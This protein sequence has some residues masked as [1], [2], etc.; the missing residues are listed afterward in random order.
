VQTCSSSSSRS[1]KR[2]TMTTYVYDIIEQVIGGQIDFYAGTTIVLKAI[3]DS[4]FSDEF[5]TIPPVNYNGFSDDE[6]IR[7]TQ[8]ISCFNGNACDN[9]VPDRRAP[10][11]GPRGILG[12]GRRS[13][14]TV[15]GPSRIGGG[16]SIIRDDDTYLSTSRF[17][18]ETAVSIAASVPNVIIATMIRQISCGGKQCGRRQGAR[19]M[20]VYNILFANLAIANCLSTV[21]L[22]F[23]NNLIYLFS[24]QLGRTFKARPC[25]FF[26][27]VA[28][29]VFTS[30][31]FGFVTTLTMLGF[32]TVQYSAICRPL[33]HRS[34]LNRCKIVIFLVVIW[35]ASLLIGLVPIGYLWASV[36]GRPCGLHRLRL[37]GIVV[38]RGAN[39][40]VAF[41]SV[42][43]F[44]IFVQCALIFRRMLIVRREMTPFRYARDMRTERRAIITIVILLLT[45]N[46]F[47]VPYTVM[48]LL[49]LNWPSTA[50]TE[51][52]ALVYYM[53]LLPHFKC[54]VDPIVYG[55]RMREMKM[56][57]TRLRKLIGGRPRRG[58]AAA[59]ASNGRC[60]T[61]R[62]SRYEVAVI[63]EAAMVETIAVG[64]LE[65]PLTS[66]D[67]TAAVEHGD[68]L[69]IQ[70]SNHVSETDD[71]E[72]F[73]LRP[74]TTINTN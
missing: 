55:L 54:M 65:R 28:S 56:C 7:S 64:V 13:N 16:N 61:C 14:Y 10:V 8:L 6:A 21:L 22:W 41:M 40:S 30:M 50:H 15:L 29:T 42:V 63:G 26:L 11:G 20:S 17:A 49:T 4:A 59:A 51:N 33:H 58:A 62:S 69:V 47:F 68:S 46:V 38:R 43:H 60:R 72:L 9:A 24:D 5:F 52:S 23:C 2:G 45:L 39:A 19:P 37:I 32:S 53:S 74:P 27:H 3:N 35:L 18:F 66:C 44:A 31:S 48:T 73:G 12:G 25:L 57:R 67:I 34:V 1:P 71:I 70:S 36:R